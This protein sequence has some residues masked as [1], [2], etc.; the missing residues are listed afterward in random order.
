MTSSLSVTAPAG[1]PFIEW[2]REFDAS[3]AAVFDAYRDPELFRQWIG[4]DD[5][6]IDLQEY[7]FRTGGTWRY[8]HRDESGSYGLRG[9]FHTVRDHELAVQTFEFDGFPDMVNLDYVTFTDL[10]DDRC[11]LTGRTVL[12]SVEARDGM[13]ASGMET[14]MGQGYD[15]LENLLTA[16]KDT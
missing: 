4:P 12:P 3:V 9:V 7:D 1:V 10:G 2:E 8:V 11:R 5:G 16:G 13:V 14:G 15:R 6:E